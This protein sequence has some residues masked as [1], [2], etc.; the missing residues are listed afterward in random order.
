MHKKHGDQPELKRL[1]GWWGHDEHT[2]FAMDGPFKAM[3]GADGW[4][5]SNDNVLGLAAHQASLEIFS[6]AGMANLR[7]KSELLTGYLEFLIRQIIHD[8]PIEIITPQ[9]PEERGCQLSIL[10][11]KG[12][13]EIFDGLY[14]HGVIGDWR[15]PNV[16]RLAP[17]PLYNGFVEVYTVAK[18]LERLL[19]NTYD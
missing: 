19:E 11:Q 17:T 7:R 4:L 18:L 15:N 9:N 13:K 14:D 5:L 2:R 3:P 16:I 6:R 10:F 1:A 12:G 8:Y